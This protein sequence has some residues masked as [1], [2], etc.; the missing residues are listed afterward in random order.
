VTAE[1][2]SPDVQPRQILNALRQGRLSRRDF[3]VRAAALG[4]SAAA[5]NAFLVACGGSATS[6]PATGGATTS[7]SSSTSKAATSSAASTSAA[8]TSAAASSAGS[9]SAASGGSSSAA[10]G[11]SSSSS[12]AGGSGTPAAAGTPAPGNAK[13]NLNNPPAVANASDAKKYSGQKITYYGDTGGI[14]N[15]LDKTISAKFQQET[16]V[17]VQVIPRPQDTNDTYALY[18][19]AF[20]GQSAGLDV[21]MIDVVYPA[22]FAPHLIDLKPKL[23]DMTTDMLKSIVDNN[24]V[25]GHL[26]AMPYF[27]DNGF[28][29]YRKDL[30]QKYSISAPP[31]TWDELQQQAKKIM[32]G[33][34]GSNP[35]FTGFV[36]Q[37]KAYE[38]LTCDALE[39][40][41]SNGG[42]LIIEGG[43]VTVDNDK[44]AAALTTIKGFVNTISPQGVTGYTETETANTFVGGNAAFARNWPYMY[45]LGVA[46]ESKINGKFDLAPLPVGPSGQKPVACLGGWQLGVP[47][48]SKVQDAAQEFVR[49]MCSKEVST[50]RAIIGNYVPL[51]TDV[52]QNADVLQAQ[53]YLK[54]RDNIDIVVRPSNGLGEKYNQ[55][56]TFFYQGVNQVLTGQDPKR[57]LQQIAQQLQAVV[58]K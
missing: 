1:Q 32:D 21:L 51:Y 25:D 6:T 13:Y 20:Q 52:A 43:K 11:S 49:Y 42:G 44:A 27:G 31:K 29:Y 56:S 38:G 58:R 19:R 54:V 3:V 12:A 57:E 37:G 35:N 45:A 2:Q 41:A 8:S 22:A 26:V 5:I 30:L 39:W 17:E 10:S 50:Y 23:G 47:K 18:Q 4:F 14:G 28:L 33:E 36:F 7:T 9:S 16:G 34:K 24:T 53:P 15:E 48:Y 40:I 46:P 55:G